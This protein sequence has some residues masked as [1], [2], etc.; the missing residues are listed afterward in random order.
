M[1]VDDGYLRFLIFSLLLCMFEN[2][3]NEQCYTHTHTH[4]H[5][6]EKIKERRGKG[7]RWDVSMGWEE[8]GRTHLIEKDL[9]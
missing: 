2:F 9:R 3:C 8:H 6:H 1:K 7:T 4:T 5:T